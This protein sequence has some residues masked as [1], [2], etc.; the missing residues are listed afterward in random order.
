MDRHNRGIAVRAVRSKHGGGLNS[1]KKDVFCQSS[2]VFR[3]EN[4]SKVSTA[5][6]SSKDNSILPVQSDSLACSVISNDGCYVAA[7]FTDG[8]VVIWGTASDNYLLK[9]SHFATT[10][11]EAV[12]VS[13]EQTLNGKCCH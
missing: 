10:E 9:Y 5:E 6:A 7:G 2:R 4:D 1:Q 8:L 3:R 11:A 13:T 12:F